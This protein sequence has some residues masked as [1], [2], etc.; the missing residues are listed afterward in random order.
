MI[1]CVQRNT[2]FRFISLLLLLTLPFLALPSFAAETVTTMAALQKAVSEAKP[3]DVITLADGNYEQGCT[4]K[5]KGTS[6]KPIVVRT[7]TLGKVGITGPVRIEG[8]YITLLGVNFTAQGRV[9][10]RGVGLRLSRCSMSN[11]RSGKW[12]T[13]DPRSSKIE[14]DHCLFEKKENNRELPRN[15]QLFQFLV[16]NKGEGHHIHH[17]H[18]RDIP[19][20]KGNGF[21][22][23]QLMTSDNPYNPKG[24]DCETV[25]EDNLFERCNG[26]GEII[27]MKSSGN[28]IRRNTFRDCRGSLVLRTGHRNQA[29]ANIF[30]GGKDT[31]SGGIRIQGKDQVVANNYFYGLKYGVAMMDGTPDDLYVRVERATIIHN[32]VVNCPRALRIGMN[33]PKHPE[34]TPPSQCV[35]A[36]NLF[37]GNPKD[38][39]AT[40]VEYIKGDEPEAWTWAGNVYSGT[41]GIPP[42]KG[43]REGTPAL[44]STKGPL[45]LPTRRTPSAKELAP[46]VKAA[47]KDMCGQTRST[48]PTAGAIQFSDKMTAVKPLTAKQVGPEAK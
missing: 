8:S 2:S 23:I 4:L 11:I 7:Q 17:N 9:H 15:C 22:T 6:D 39:A 16:R 25:I 5:G 12:V 40:I 44:S 33:H 34:G 19:R 3:G 28:I 31:G 30:I 47:A 43:L 20:G 38:K 24:G 1:I 13:V 21:E 41:L 14:V 37:V 45:P 42:T 29:V 46:P 48:T 27:S 10:M 32:T 26:E 35:V 36:N 18:F